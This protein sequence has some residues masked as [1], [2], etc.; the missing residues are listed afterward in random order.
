MNVNQ[1]HG[2]AL[3]DETKRAL[4]RYKQGQDILS[5]TEPAWA[6]ILAILK[7]DI[8][9]AAKKARGYRDSDPNEAFR[10]LAELQGREDALA[11]LERKARSLTALV[12]NPPDSIQPYINY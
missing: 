4:D 6:T 1:K 11:N 10:L 3:S 12:E 2:P 9:S 7:E 5:V 8:E